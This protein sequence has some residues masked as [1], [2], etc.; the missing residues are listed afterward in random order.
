MSVCMP[1]SAYGKVPQ[2]IEWFLKLPKS[3]K[4][5][6]KIIKCLT[7]E[8]SQKETKGSHKGTKGCQKW[9]KNQEN[10]Q[11]SILGV[12]EVFVL[13][14]IIFFIKIVKTVMAHL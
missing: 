3:N 11:K 6:Q 10:H 4:N 5:K 14:G 13:S 2:S 12:F 9:T 8:E 7:F 1:S